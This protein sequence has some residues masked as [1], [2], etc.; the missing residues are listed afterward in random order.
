MRRQQRVGEAYQ[1]MCDPRLKKLLTVAIKPGL[2]YSQQ[3]AWGASAVCSSYPMPPQTKVIKALRACRKIYADKC[4]EAGKG[5]SLIA[6]FCSEDVGAKTKSIRTEHGAFEDQ[7]S[8]ATDLNKV[9]HPKI[10]MCH[11]SNQA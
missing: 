3:I 5:H 6:T 2:V 9:K 7:F 4:T 10:S 11:D 8:V 1:T